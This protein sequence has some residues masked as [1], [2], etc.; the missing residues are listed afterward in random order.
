VT[1]KVLFV[2]DE[3]NTLQ[4]LR[5]E[6]RDWS[7]T[8]GIEV[9]TTT[10][11]LA[12]IGMLEADKDA[13]ELIVSDLRMPSMKGS[14]LLIAVKERFPD[15]MSILLTGYAEVQEVMRAVKAGIFSYIL[16]PW[17][18]DYL[19]AE[20]DK[21]L[22]VYR[23]R[24]ENAEHQKRVDMELRWA[25]EMQRAFLDIRI[26]ASKGLQF[27]AEYRPLSSL[28]C[29]GDYYDFLQLSDGRVLV[30][31]GDVS[32]HGVTGALMTGILKSI[33]GPGYIVPAAGR[34]S[35]AALL[36]WLNRRLVS[37]LGGGSSI[38]IS[39]VACLVDPTARTMRYANAGQTPPLLVSGGAGTPLDSTGPAVGFVA[40]AAYE[41]RVVSLGSG[42]LLVF[43]T[44]GLV[45]VGSGH[46]SEGMKR[47]LAL[48]LSPE[49]ASLSAAA[50]ADRALE[51]SGSKAFEDDVTVIRAQV[52]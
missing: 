26:P 17:D 51:L 23:I 20:I 25:G 36:G 7:R 47:L 15:I 8:T 38:F 46:V 16:K 29:S 12:V 13:Y 50:I 21:A 34:A 4:T 19:R 37:F 43:Y 30:L 3:P 33:I 27:D 44:D 45:E 28:Y 42:D 24:K 10:D 11:P 6:L 22:S 31:L 35:P 32:G 52:T 49:G 1:R 48:L 9:T 18:G 2:D 39:L 5:R 41:E 40:D 14:D